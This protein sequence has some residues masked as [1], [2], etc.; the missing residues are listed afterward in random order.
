[1]FKTNCPDNV[2]ISRTLRNPK[3][4]KIIALLFSLIKNAIRSHGCFAAKWV[5]FSIRSVIPP[6]ASF[7]FP[8]PLGIIK[9]AVFE[10]IIEG[11]T[12]HE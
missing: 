12:P 4:G 8:E 2:Q 7:F 1:M 10:M 9:Q 5:W 11:D 3:G 6:S